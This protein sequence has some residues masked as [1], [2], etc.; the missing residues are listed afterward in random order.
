MLR[1]RNTENAISL[2]VFAFVNNQ[3][4]DERYFLALSGMFKNYVFINASYCFSTMTT[5]K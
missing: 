5:L 1:V 4:E 3:P 2:A